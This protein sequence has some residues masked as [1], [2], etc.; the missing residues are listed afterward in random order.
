MTAVTCERCRRAEASVVLS[1]PSHCRLK[2]KVLCHACAQSPDLP[3][4]FTLRPIRP[5]TPPD[6]EK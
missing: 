5:E 3:S 4:P 2:E 6:R 1:H